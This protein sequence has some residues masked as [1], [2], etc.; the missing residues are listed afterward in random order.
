MSSVCLSNVGTG[1]GFISLLVLSSWVYFILMKRKI[2]KLREKFFQQNGGLILHQQ[3]CQQE[4]STETVKIFTV[5][6]LQKATKNYDESRIIGRGGFGTVFKGFLADNKII[7]IK[8][9]KIEDENQIEQF[10]NEVVVLSQINHRHVVKLL[11]CCL[12]TQVPLLVNEFVQN[13]T[14]FKHIHQDSNASTFPWE[15]RLRI[16]TETAK[17]IW[18]M[19]S[20]ASIPI[21]HRDVK[22]TNILLNDD[23]TAKVSDFGTSRLVPRNQTQLATVV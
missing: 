13:D 9:S 22:S 17:A 10:I 2:L 19:H 8:K 14:L 1:V 7:A 5:D 21:I 18:Y 3:L 23:F 12:E 15:T 6:E 11:G 20:A 4:G 16:A